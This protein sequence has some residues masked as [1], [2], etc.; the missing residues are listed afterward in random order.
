MDLPV[1]R[2]NYKGEIHGVESCWQLTDE[3]IQEIVNSGKIYFAVW[4][5]THP[6]IC[7]ST[8]SIVEDGDS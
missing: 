2:F 7:L 8:S 1:T 6:P 4:G 3:E 5:N